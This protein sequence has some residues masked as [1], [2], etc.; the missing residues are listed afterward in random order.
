MKHNLRA[1]LKK[2]RF[3][4]RVFK[5]CEIPFGFHNAKRFCYSA[6]SVLG[7]KFEQ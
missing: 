7:R 1:L 5:S 2:S 6:S 3:K 4:S